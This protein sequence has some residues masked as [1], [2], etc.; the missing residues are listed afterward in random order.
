MLL[1]GHLVAGESGNRDAVNNKIAPLYFY[2]DDSV[3]D[4]HQVANLCVV[5]ISCKTTS[6]IS[7]MSN[8]MLHYQLSGLS[9]GR[10][11]A[12]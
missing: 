4:L 7:L 12:R 1:S 8:K 9:G 3:L 11:I 6:F 2:L 10:F 5:I